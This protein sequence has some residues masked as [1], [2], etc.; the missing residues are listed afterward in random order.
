MCAIDVVGQ[1]TEEHQQLLPSLLSHSLSMMALPKQIVGTST[2]YYGVIVPPDGGW[3][4]Y[5]HK[6]L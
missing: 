5:Q 2:R 4:S 6:V 3:K 1:F